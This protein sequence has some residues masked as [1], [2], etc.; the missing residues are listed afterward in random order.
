M[1]SFVKD[2]NKTQL[3]LHRGI[4]KASNNGN[5]QRTFTLPL[6]HSRA[7]PS[8]RSGQDRSQCSFINPSMAV[9]RV[10]LKKLDTLGVMVAHNNIG[11]Q[12]NN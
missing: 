3:T 10:I 6:Q 2:C 5:A 4:M 11:L 12:H 1:F 7:R 9:I 8:P